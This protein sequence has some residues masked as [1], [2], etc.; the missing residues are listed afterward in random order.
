MATKKKQ[1][2]KDGTKCTFSLRG[3]EYEFFDNIDLMSSYDGKTCI[4]DCLET[5]T[6]LGNKEYE[7]YNITFEDGY[8]IIGCS[9][10]YLEYYN[11]FETE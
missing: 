9:G 10:Y 2:F 5:Y 11:N 6:E 1:I 8:V 7:Y 3:Y 4:I